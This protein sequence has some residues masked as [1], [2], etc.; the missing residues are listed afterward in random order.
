MLR[1]NAGGSFSV[2]A[3]TDP[4]DVAV[5]DKAPGTVHCDG[6]L[7]TEPLGLPGQRHEA[8]LKLV[9]DLVSEHSGRGTVPPPQL[10][11]LPHTILYVW[12]GERRTRPSVRHLYQACLVRRRC[13]C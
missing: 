8:R 7:P 13:R 9:S 4:K 1:A 3:S 2:A 5:G 12:G 11:D 6:C 10:Q